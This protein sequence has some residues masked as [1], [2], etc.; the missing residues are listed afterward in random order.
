MKKTK[1]SFPFI[2]H[3][4]ALPKKRF[5]F[6]CKISR[7]QEGQSLVELLVAIGLSSLFIPVLLTGM[8]AARS[9]RAQ[10][11]QRTQAVSFAKEASEVV[12]VIRDGNWNN[13]A[14]FPSG[15]MLHPVISGSTWTLLPG[16]EF[17]NG[18]GFTRQI[19]INDV[20]RDANGNIVISGGTLDLSTRKVVVTVSWTSPLVS[21]VS[22]SFY[23]TRSTNNAYKETTQSDFL[24]GVTLSG[25]LAITNTFG[26]EITLGAG[27]GAG[28]D[29]CAPGDSV[30]KQADLPG[31]GVVQAISAT[32]SASLD[33][34]YTTTG[35]NASGDSVDV[36]TVDHNSPPNIV[37]N[38]PLASNNEAKAYGIYIDH[39]GGN[40][41]FNENRPPNHT[42]QIANYTTLTDAGY[43]D[44]SGGGTGS[45]VYVLGTIGYT[46]VENTL[47][48]F[49]V[50]TI[51]GSSSQTELGKVTLAAAG[52][53]VVVVKDPAS[54]TLYAYVTE[55][56]S[57]KQMEIFRVNA[58]GTIVSP[59]VANAQIANAAKGKDVFVNPSGTRAYLITNQYNLGQNQF[60][61]I[62]TQTK[63]GNL[64]APL[65][66]FS[67]YNA[68]LSAGMDPKGV[69]VVTGNK[70]I[71]VGSGGQQYQVYNLANESVIRY[72]GGM[73]L[74]DGIS[75]NAISS[76]YRSDQTAYSYILTSDSS[77]ELQIIQGGNGTAFSFSGTFES[78]TF[79][80]TSD[81][82][83]NTFTTTTSVPSST[84]LQFQV[85][86]KHA[87]NNNCSG[88]TFTNADFV[89]P[90][91]TSTSYFSSDGGI[92]PQSNDQI[93]FENPGQCLRYRANL[94]SSDITESPELYDITFNYSP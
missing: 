52:N 56:S 41:Y 88:V 87:V 5:A 72:C 33:Y 58:D 18:F 23:L 43:Y 22:E 19:L 61:I 63:S 57:T 26:G 59:A 68:T 7:L 82:M 45:S 79:T 27:N 24:K 37:S 51:R 13:F 92:I 55:D 93:G 69:T 38:P 17:I 73:K 94:A 85:A 12:R 28:S 49:D 71:V 14:A 6:F 2:F 67:T 65:G 35:N 4:L 89:G 62:N 76:L 48:T 21:S 74:A 31:Q 42:V 15:Q 40:V 54:G 34:I 53:R 60:F 81:A 29:W 25:K 84:T 50:G 9:G 36:S 66:A 64:P 91:G 44:S 78:Q 77:H 1:F 20:F 86:I 32:T 83:F 8:I 80:A 47:Y 10:E 30:L 3:A 39:A 90:N 16:S 75:I 70:A 46:T 11:D